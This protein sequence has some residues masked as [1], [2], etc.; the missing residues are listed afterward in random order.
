[1]LVSVIR[2]NPESV[3]QYASAA[4]Q[5]FDAVRVELQ[6]LVSDAV[7]VRYFGPNAVSFKTHCGQMASDF[8]R[9]LA[10]DLGQIA[11][12]VRSSTTAIAT[13][14][15]GGPVS[16]SVS[17]APIPLPQVMAS[18]GSVEV[19]TSGLVGLKP[20]VGHR[21]DAIAEQIDAHLR[22]L[23]ATDWQ[24]QAKETAVNAVAGFS[25]AAKNMGNE[26]RTSITSYIDR[27]ITAV[28]AG[29]R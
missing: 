6:G 8:G 10:V 5:Q 15:G 29:D 7:T 1:M 14:L 25:A 22:N 26:A 2:V 16:V 24:G 9:R 19:D 13:S 27:Q 28:F 20:V 21:I 11:D 17:G 23:Q 12:A 3:H 18:D 4:Q